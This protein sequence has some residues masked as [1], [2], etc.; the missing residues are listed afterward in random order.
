MIGDSENFIW[1]DGKSAPQWMIENMSKFTRD[2]EHGVDASESDV[3]WNY[4]VY[5]CRS[6]GLN[7]PDKEQTYRKKET[8]DKTYFTLALK[9]FNLKFKAIVDR[10]RNRISDGRR[11]REDF[12][13]LSSRYKD[14]KIIDRDGASM[15]EVVIA[16][17]QRFDTNVM[18]T[19]TCED[20]S[21]EWFWM[22]L[23]NASLDIFVDSGFTVEDNNASIMCDSIL[24]MINDRSYSKD[25]KGGFFPLKHSKNDQT[26]RE[27]WLQMHEYFLENSIE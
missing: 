6:V 17:C 27:L 9:M 18:M 1:D 26:K 7:G 4:F 14:Y 5:L 16:M 21:S 25:G 2:D 22:M 15:L 11:L 20:R 12:A 24:E 23:K 19:E 13:L 3:L 10:D 8:D